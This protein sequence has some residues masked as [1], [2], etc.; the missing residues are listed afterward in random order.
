MQEIY[1][2]FYSQL[3][4]SLPMKDAIFRSRLV[5]LL[6]DDLKETVESKSTAA[7]AASCFLDNMIKPAVEFGNNTPFEILLAKMEESENIN[8][9]TLAQNIKEEIQSLPTKKPIVGKIYIENIFY[10]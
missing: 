9:N 3:V 8:L 1:F 5:G 2:K 7:E 4:S 6:P 10:S